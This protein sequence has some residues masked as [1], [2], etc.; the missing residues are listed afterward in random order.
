VPNIWPKNEL[1]PDDNLPGYDNSTDMISELMLAK[2]DLPKIKF[3]VERLIQQVENLPTQ[4]GSPIFEE[5][6]HSSKAP[7]EIA[8][9]KDP[10]PTQTWYVPARYFARQLVKN[11]PALEKKR[12]LLAK[13]IIPLLTEAGFNKR[14]GKK[15]LE[16]GTILKALSNILLK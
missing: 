12:D 3:A 9:P 10:K 2:S 8:D 16:P 14:G 15:P 6:Q 11:K 7:W 13:Q 5:Q 1:D 4:T